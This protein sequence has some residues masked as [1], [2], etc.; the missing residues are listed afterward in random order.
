M[1]VPEAG[2]YP[3]QQGTGRE[4]P[5]TGHQ[6]RSVPHLD[7]GFSSFK[8]KF[9]IYNDTE[10]PWYRCC[11][12]S[13]FPRFWNVIASYGVIRAGK[14]GSPSWCHGEQI[15]MLMVKSSLCPSQTRFIPYC[16]HIPLSPVPGLPQ[17]YTLKVW[18]HIQDGRWKWSW[19]LTAI[20]TYIYIYIEKTSPRKARMKQPCVC[21]VGQVCL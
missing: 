19:D 17:R 7:L 9:Q 16:W 6:R 20:V 8:P 4:S 13:C 14:Q 3:I 11:C 18:I 1:F 10:N 5:N 21:I 15:Y 12:A 2:K